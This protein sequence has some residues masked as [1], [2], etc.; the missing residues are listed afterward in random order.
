MASVRARRRKPDPTSDL[1][2]FVVF[3]RVVV[4]CYVAFLVVSTHLPGRF[5]V[6][7]SPG[8]VS[9]SLLGLIL[10][11]VGLLAPTTLG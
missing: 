3:V 10:I 6:T 2:F 11:S 8:V 1:S 4:L 5:I 9:L 7:V